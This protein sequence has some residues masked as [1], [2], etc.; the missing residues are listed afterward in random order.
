MKKLVNKVVKWA[1]DRNLL[2]GSS[3]DRQIYKTMEEVTELAVAIGAWSHEMNYDADGRDT[4]G[5]TLE[6]KDAIGDVTVTLIIIAKQ[7][8]LDFEDCLA[9][10]W[11]EIK[12]RRGKMV[13]GVF[14]KD[15]N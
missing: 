4:D 9:A 6:I 12:D 13:N 8:G 1:E 14:V 5:I 11:E 3:P 10:V 2:E 15:L 7:L